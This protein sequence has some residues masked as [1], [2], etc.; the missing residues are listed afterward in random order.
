MAFYEITTSKANTFLTEITIFKSLSLEIFISNTT[1][2]LYF[3]NKF[4]FMLQKN[5]AHLETNVQ[6][7]KGK[8]GTH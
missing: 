6:L 4:I 2:A 5:A 7:P 3:R 8:R 1:I